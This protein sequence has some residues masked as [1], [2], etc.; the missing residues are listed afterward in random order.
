MIW[1]WLIFTAVFISM[2]TVDLLMRKKDHIIG[3][4]EAL[5]WSAFFVGVA[6]VFNV[7][8]YLWY[9]H[10]KAIQF[11]TAYLIEKALS[12][13]NI[14][15]FIMIFAYFKVP[16]E[17]EHK[18]LFWGVLGAIVMRAIFIFAGLA[19]IEMFH[20]VLY[21]F[22]GFLIITGIKMAIKDDNEVHPEKNPVLKLFR[23]LVPV[24]KDYHGHD[25]FIKRGKMLAATPL[26]VVLI[27]IETTDLIF[28]LDSIPAVL[29]ISRDSFIVYT[30]NIFAIL[31]LRALY[32]ALAGLMKLFRFLNYGLALILVFIGVK[33]LLPEEYKIPI[34]YVLTMIM[35]VLSISIVL[36]L[37][38]PEKTGQSGAS[39]DP[40]NN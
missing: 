4:K 10:E 12:I 18:V 16:P 8:V 1:W 37:L 31:G 22:G 38:I 9:D 21:I 29:A 23:K 5:L 6:M 17:Y 3:M 25:F 2:L 28:A 30:S 35:T 20:W 24:T 14:F 34:F 13:D 40:S 19:I 27:M 33:M 7:V 15:V 39:G 32:F 11:L 26:F 36:S